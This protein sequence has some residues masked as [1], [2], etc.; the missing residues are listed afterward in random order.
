MAT[1]LC[2]NVVCMA[3]ELQF[4]GT[5]SGFLLGMVESDVSNSEHWTLFFLVVDGFF[6]IIYASDVLIRIFFLRPLGHICRPDA[7]FV[8]RRATYVPL[9][10]L[11]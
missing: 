11:G 3:L 6:N 1:I 2:V 10:S 8:W 7:C 4:V 5:Q 9:V